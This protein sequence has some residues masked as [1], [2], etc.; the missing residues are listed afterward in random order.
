MVILLYLEPD[1]LPLNNQIEFHRL[2]VFMIVANSLK[3]K[4]PSPSLSASSIISYISS[5][6]RF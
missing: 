1:R 2:V 4:N 6:D 3:F 5:S